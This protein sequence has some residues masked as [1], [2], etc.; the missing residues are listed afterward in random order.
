M[1]YICMKGSDPELSNQQTL[2]LPLPPPKFQN[3]YQKL[4]KA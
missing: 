1:L 3:M 2:N 4:L